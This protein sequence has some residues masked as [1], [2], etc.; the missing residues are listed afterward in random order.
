MPET[1]Y[2]CPKHHIRLRTV[3]DYP[4]AL[5]CPSGARYCPTIFIVIDGHL[6]RDDGELSG[7]TDVKTGEVREI[8]E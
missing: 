2:K 8:K 4:G 3:E 1:T 5:L 7:W 6:C